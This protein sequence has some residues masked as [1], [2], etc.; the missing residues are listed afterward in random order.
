MQF[1]ISGRRKMNVFSDNVSNSGAGGG[2]NP[3]KPQ[4]DAQEDEGTHKS[5]VTA[6]LVKILDFATI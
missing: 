4:A 5:L 2:G 3:Q 6:K 1:S